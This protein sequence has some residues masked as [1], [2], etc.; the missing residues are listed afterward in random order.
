MKKAALGFSWCGNT[1]QTWRWY[2][3]VMSR[4]HSHPQRLYDNFHTAR[5][6]TV[7]S[8]EIAKRLLNVCGT[9]WTVFEGDLWSQYFWVEHWNKAHNKSFPIPTLSRRASLGRFRSIQRPPHT[10]GTTQ[11]LS[12]ER[13]NFQ[14]WTKCGLGKRVLNHLKRLL[15]RRGVLAGFMSLVYSSFEDVCREKDAFCVDEYSWDVI[16]EKRCSR[17]MLIDTVPVADHMFQLSRLLASHMNLMI[18]MAA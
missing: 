11:P 17:N 10:R 1:A 2:C 6:G 3:I 8:A 9:L 4:A 16:P 7:Y 15:L 14:R 13:V 18:Q 5:L 12:A